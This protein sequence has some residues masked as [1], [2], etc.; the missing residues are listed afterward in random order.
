VGN[1]LLTLPNVICTPHLG[2]SSVQAQA[3]VARAIASQIL[4]FLQPGVIRNAVNF[5]SMR[6]KYFEKIRPYLTLEALQNH[7]NIISV[8]QVRL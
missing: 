2:A 3:N 7:P 1:P 6:P 5:P 8:Q 4:D